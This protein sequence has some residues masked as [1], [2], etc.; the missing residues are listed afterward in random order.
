MSA[1][2]C[3]CD[4]TGVRWYSSYATGVGTVDP[5]SNS[6]GLLF[7]MSS[8]P[9]DNLDNQCIAD[10]LLFKILFLV[11]P[12]ILVTDSS[13]C[14]SLLGSIFGVQGLLINCVLYDLP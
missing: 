9:T 4:V 11:Y 5:E 2:C 14:H 6:Y 12:R 3:L 10:F 8:M 1:N 13:T 7:K